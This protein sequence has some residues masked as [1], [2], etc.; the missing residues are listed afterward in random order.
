M[1]FKAKQNLLQRHVKKC[2]KLPVLNLDHFA[3]IRLVSKKALIQVAM[4]TESM[5][6]AASKIVKYDAAMAVIAQYSAKMLKQE[7]DKSV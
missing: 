1:V 4:A 5:S 2:L 3:A 7:V 6:I